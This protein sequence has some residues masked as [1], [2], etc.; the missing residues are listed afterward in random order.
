MDD[1]GMT[2]HNGPNLRPLTGFFSLRTKLVL[3]ISLIIIAVCS[4][5]SWYSFIS[6]PKR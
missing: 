5:L 1:T 2:A 4:G 6:K 3:F